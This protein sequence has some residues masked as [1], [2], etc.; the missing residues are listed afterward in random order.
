MKPINI[1]Y[2]SC[3]KYLKGKKWRPYKNLKQLIADRIRAQLPGIKPNSKDLEDLE[4]DFKGF[5]LP[6]EPGQRT[7]NE[8]IARYKNEENVAV[9][10]VKLS[11]CDKCSRQGTDYFE[12]VLQV[13]SSDTKILEKGVELLIQ[14]VGA[15][16][17]KGVFIN[18]V[19]RTKRGFNLFI[20]DKKHALRLGQWLYEEL[21]GVFKTS[22]K[23]YS[24]D[25]QTSKKVYRLNILVRLPGFEKGDII[26][27]SNNKV[28]AVRGLGRK[29]TLEELDSEKI[30]KKYYSTLNYH[31][32]AR[33]KTYV[34]RIRPGLEVINPLDYQSVPVKNKTGKDQDLK[35]GDEVSVV[36][37]KGA[38]L[39]G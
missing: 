14:K 28:C 18:K 22:P 8:V 36:V 5:E 24:K 34:S 19:K 25:R 4:L 11:K 1:T 10:V 17:H 13:R 23:L 2:C 32:L 3:E 12:A 30:L 6:E 26:L 9:V 33:H 15:L 31:V 27:L 16:K 35:P 39:V 21:G 20:T 29:I 37:H 38:Y 7:E